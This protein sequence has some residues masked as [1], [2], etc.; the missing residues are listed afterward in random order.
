MITANK[1]VKSAIIPIMILMLEF[2]VNIK[3]TIAP[4]NSTALRKTDMI[5][6]AR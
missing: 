1:Q 5:A 3:H 4:I 2:E 6:P